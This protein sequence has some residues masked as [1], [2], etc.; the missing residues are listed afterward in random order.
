MILIVVNIERLFSKRARRLRSSEI[1]ELLKVTQIPGMISLGG[2]LPNPKAFPVEIIHKC[3][4]KVFKENSK[5]ALQYGTTEGLTKLRAALA[6]RMKKKKDIDCELH[7]V[8]IT[9]GA[10]QA[11]MLSALCFLDPGD[12]Y[13]ASVPAYLGAIQAFH[14]F[15]GNCE[16]IPMDEEGID[17]DSLR[18]NVERLRRTGINPKFLYAVPTF[19]NPSGRTMSIDHRKELLDIASEYDF[20]IIEDDP[21]G[22]LS[23]NNEKYPP[24]KSFDK[25]GR[26]IYMSTFSKILAPGFRLGWMNASKEIIDRLTLAKQA[27]D[28]CTNVFSQYVAYEYIN[29]GYLDQQVKKIRKMYKKKRDVMLEAIEKHFPQGVNWTIP[30][31]GMFIWIELPKSLD[32]RLMFKKALGKK[33]AYVIGEAFFPDGGNYNSMRLNFSY[34]DDETIREGIKRLAE[35]IKEEMRST[36]QEDAFLPE[37]V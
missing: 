30:K 32:T 10:Q 28:L 31:G 15:E 33:V 14:A 19:Q 36:Y 37:G 29:G 27:A 26:V 11:L 20:L 7:D 2:G 18:R 34:S 13:L 16:S 21:Y 1:R 4:D 8:L 23:F 6:E 17:T 3:I 22:D 9:S 25:K 24:I 5:D 12:T 35:L